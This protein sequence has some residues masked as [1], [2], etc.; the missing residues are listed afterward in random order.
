MAGS[1]PRVST[2]TRQLPM[3]LLFRV[4]SFLA[5]RALRMSSL[6]MSAPSPLVSRPLVES[7]RSSS[8]VTPSFLP[9]S[10]RCMLPCLSCL[11]D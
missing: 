8:P 9:A 6:L 11:T 7:S 5:S 4:V 10:P 2:P 1:L 3:V